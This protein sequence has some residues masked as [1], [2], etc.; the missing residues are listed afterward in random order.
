MKQ[1]FINLPVNDLEKS[2][3]FY[4]ALGL[5]L[6]PLFTDEQQKCVIW[7]DAIYLMIQSKQFANTYLNRSAEKVDKPLSISHTL[8]VASIEIVNSMVEAVIKLGAT[9]PVP[10]LDEPFMYLRSVEDLDGHLWGIMYLDVE[11]FIIHSTP[12]LSLKAPK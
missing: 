10:V 7:S 3:Q 8:P 9:E 2:L 1:I 4:L 12:N 5:T 11:K 6:H